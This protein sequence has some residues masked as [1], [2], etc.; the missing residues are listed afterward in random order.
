MT[1][2]VTHRTPAQRAMYSEERIHVGNKKYAVYLD[3]DKRS[4]LRLRQE[5]GELGEKIITMDR[6]ADWGYAMPGSE[7][8]KRAKL[9]AEKR[10]EAERLSAAEVV[11]ASE[12]KPEALVE[13]DPEFNPRML[14][15]YL[16]DEVNLM[17]CLQELCSSEWSLKHFG[18]QHPILIELDEGLYLRRKQMDG[19]YSYSLPQMQYAGKTYLIHRMQTSEFER[20]KELVQKM[21]W[22]CMRL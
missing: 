12:T 9:R 3:W 5:T 1:I 18:F 4:L 13:T 2:F 20:L 14:R 11:L 10:A 21:Q 6:M 8:E 15:N 22:T 16:Q 19:N 7:A 17:S